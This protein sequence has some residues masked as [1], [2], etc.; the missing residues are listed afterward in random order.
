MNAQEQLALAIG[1]VLKEEPNATRFPP[2]SIQFSEFVV[3]QLQRQ[4]CVIKE[5]ELISADRAG[6]INIAQVFTSLTDEGFTREE[7]M[8][9]LKIMISAHAMKGHGI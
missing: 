9:L 1:V 8:D 5:E 7:A 6:A 4:N 2:T 3:R